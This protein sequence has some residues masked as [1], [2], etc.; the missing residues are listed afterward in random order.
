M[1]VPNWA[2]QT[3]STFNPIIYWAAQPDSTFNQMVYW[4]AQSDSTFNPM[5]YWPAQPDSTLN[6]DDSLG[7]PLKIYEHC[8]AFLGSPHMHLRTLRR[9]MQ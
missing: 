8:F 4:A 6:P 5:V 1:I 3:D 7:Y 2:A 9:C